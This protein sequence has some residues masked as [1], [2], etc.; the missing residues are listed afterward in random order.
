MKNKNKFILYIILI[1]LIS[2]IFCELFLKRI[3][4]N[5]VTFQVLEHYE[6]R[7]DFL[8]YLNIIITSIISITI[9]NLSKRIAEQN[10][11]E[12]EIKKYES[13]CNVYDY[14]NETILNIKKE[15]FHDKEDY[16]ILDYNVDFMKNCYNIYTDIFDEY[17]LEYLRK[18][19]QT[20]K[21][22]LNRDKNSVEEKLLVKWVYKIIFD[23]NIEIDEIEK[24]NND[25]RIKQQTL[26]NDADT[27]Y[28]PN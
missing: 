20:L 10:N 12:K 16:H 18:L 22:Y 26:P 2:F 24:M 4:S 23:M 6:N 27:T 1:F 8:T 3:I 15:V 14:L 25:Q 9:Y 19:N 17:D 28:I 7:S 21:Y 13:V 5:S 11:N